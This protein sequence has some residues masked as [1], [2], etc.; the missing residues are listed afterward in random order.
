MCIKKV[1]GI[2]ATSVVTKT[3]TTEIPI[4]IGGN[5]INRKTVVMNVTSVGKK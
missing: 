4:H 1:G 2:I 5:M 3:R